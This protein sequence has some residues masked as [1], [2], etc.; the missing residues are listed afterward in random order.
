M[1]F[2]SHSFKLFTN[3][4]SYGSHMVAF[5][6]ISLI[7]LIFS[8]PQLSP[9]LVSL[10]LCR[11]MLMLSGSLLV[12][13]SGCLILMKVAHCLLPLTWCPVLSPSTIWPYAPKHVSCTSVRPKVIVMTTSWRWAC[14]TQDQRFEKWKMTYLFFLYITQLLAALTS[15]HKHILTF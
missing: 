1:C 3:M 13:N 6:P 15:V 12:L 7:F 5:T 9:T 10:S 8:F 14:S 2:I 4:I 11:R